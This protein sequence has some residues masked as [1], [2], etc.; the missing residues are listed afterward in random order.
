[1]SAQDKAA[2][3]FEYISK[4]YAI[5]L[6]V[7]RLVSGYDDLFW[8]QAD[9]IPCTYCRVKEFDRGNKGNEVNESPETVAEDGWLAVYKS[10]YDDPPLLPP[11]LKEWVAQSTN[12]TKKP[13]PSL[14]REGG[15]KFEDSAARLAALNNYLETQWGPWAKEVLP[16]FK[17]NELYD[18]LFSLH[19]RL[20]VEGDRIEILWGHLFLAWNYSAGIKIHHPLLL[21][22]LDLEFNPDRRKITLRPAQTR[23]T[24]FD[25]ECLRDLDYPNKD[26]L[27]KYAAKIN[28]GDM[29]PEVW[30]HGQMRGIATTVTGLLS[31]APVEETN[32]YEDAPIAQPPISS[33]PTIYNAPFIF[34]RQRA[35]HFWIDDA[36]K[37]AESVL[38]GDQLSPF[39]RSLVADQSAGQTPKP[40]EPLELDPLELEPLEAGSLEPGTPESAAAVTVVNNGDEG[41]DEGE[42]FFPLEYNDQQ[43]EILDRLKERFGVLVQG[44]PG[45]GKSHTIAN[46]ISSLLARGKRVLVTSQTENA[47]KV[48]RD[49]IPPEIK[50]LCVSQLGSDAESKKQLNDSVVEIGKRLAMR[51]SREHE[52]RIRHIGSELKTVREEQARLHQQIRDW[53]E[54]DSCKI[55]I[56]GSEVSAHQAAKECSQGDRR[57]SWLPD[58]LAPE[59]EPPLSDAELKELC[60]LLGD[61]SPEDRKA[62]LQYF[63]DPA[64]IQSPENISRVFDNLRF[65]SARGAETEDLRADWRELHEAAPEEILNVISILEP[66]LADLKRLDADWRLRL[67]NLMVSGESQNAFW[68]EF[69]Q[70]CVELYELAFPSFQK[71]QGYEI[72]VAEAPPDFDRDA[73]LEEL[74]V[75]VEK[76]KS[77]SSAVTRLWLSQEAKLFFNSVRVDGRKLTTLERIDLIRALFS[78]EDYLKKLEL[79]WEQGIR[80][81][82]GPGRDA[83]ALMPLADVE[84][85]LKDFRG[86]VEWIDKHLTQIGAALISL[87]C[88]DHKRIFHKGSSLGEHLETLQG[89]VAAIDEKR[90]S[91]YLRQYQKDLSGEIKKQ[92]AHSLWARFAAAVKERSAADYRAAYEEALRLTGLRPDAIKLDQLMKRLQS[93]APKWTP[94]IEAEATKSGVKA[95]P[96]DWAQAW[97]WRR[98]NEWLIRLHNRE[99]VESL[100]N[101]LERARKVERELITQLV[102]ERTWERQIENIEDRQYL[103]LTAWAN[104]MKQFGKGTGKY[105]QR[106]LAA[107]NR[108]MTEAVGAVPVWIM[109]LFRVVQSF[110]AKPGAFDVIIVDEAS[111]CDL[112]ALPVL[113]RGN[114]VLIVGDPE[115]ISPA[116]VGIEKEKIYELNRQFLTN[117]PYPERFDIDHSLYDITGTIPEIDRILLTEHFRCVPPIIEFN[118]HLSPSYGGRLEPLRRPSPQEILDPPIQTVFVENGYKNTND[119]NEPEAERVVESLVNLCHDPRYALVGSNRRKR[120]VGIISLL[121]E[122]QAKY[123]SNL[124]ARH[125]DLDEREREER[126][127]ICGDAYAF[128]GDERDVMFLSMVVATNAPFAPQVREDARRRFNVA[129]SRARDQVFLFHSVRLGDINN[130]ECVRHKLLS[131]YLNPPKS[132]VEA[133]L[134]ILKQTAD[135]EFEFEVGESIID[136]G[137]TVIPQFRPFPRDFQYRIDLVVEGENS[138]VAIECDGDQWPGA[139]KWEYDQ[140]R[141]AQLRRA[142]WKFWR[143]SGSAFYRNKEKAMD[144]LWDFLESAGVNPN[145]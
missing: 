14:A 142:G 10:S 38:A 111:Q 87:G 65:A 117:I 94:L 57:H 29:P 127:I 21:T 84:S 11:I 52:E 1:M 6:P 64:R 16:L 74:R 102:T 45:T 27:L 97:R 8:R 5:D 109:P 30:N 123:I 88:P 98:L 130:P 125:P 23:T 28:G 104:A 18:Q 7:A 140:H 73:A 40:P 118:N 101:R 39:I 43:K 92:D 83:E 77:P 113:Y 71:I 49:L 26:K 37:T 31:T 44:P 55:T 124:I 121:G 12:P 105:A 82:D 115:Q 129:T 32:L 53:A 99:S 51:N 33:I 128:Q 61:I 62:C 13:K 100:Q 9:L 79:R 135:S 114:K 110:E 116:N 67:L 134:N 108:A 41:A 15:E 75:T 68:R 86:V 59:T 89:Q 80:N 17:A 20:S 19:Q 141:E 107:A 133:G 47:L 4:V 35:R 56:S 34:V 137:Y 144:G 81:V 126:R 145:N 24:Q 143:I 138:R 119:I 22:P 2:N 131:W 48:L 46:I 72:S 91:D 95:L 54:L 76:G 42:L 3:L 85:R 60:A 63:P 103:A 136:R 78:Y 50:S 58:R 132:E 112:R 122:K 96:R 36:Q 90:L 93:V 25:L 106:H 66:A 120:T 70:A 139:E 69:L